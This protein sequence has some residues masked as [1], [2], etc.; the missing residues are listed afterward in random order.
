MT[1]ATNVETSAR[2]RAGSLLD[3]L[4]ANGDLDNLVHLA[5]LVGS[6]EDSLTDDMVGR[7]ARVIS[8]GLFLVDRLTRSDGFMRIVAILERE[9]I[10][11][12]LT[13]TLQAVSK[14]SEDARS[15]ARPKGGFGSAIRL[16]SDP[17][18]QS[19]LQLMAGVCRNLTA[20]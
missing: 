18:T 12:A 17:D 19:A 7:L 3:E 6:A 14:A 16:L 8:E 2:D 5:R 11:E 9:D 13:N 20:K 4:V 1:E 10:Q 15:A